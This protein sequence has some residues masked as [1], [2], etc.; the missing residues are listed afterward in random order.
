MTSL[1][2][3]T[4]N[5]TA[6]FIRSMSH[7]VLALGGNVGEVESTFRQALRALGDNGV[8]VLGAHLICI[9]HQWGTPCLKHSLDASIL[10]LSFALAKLRVRRC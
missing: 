7:A 10:S 6:N 8:K 1:A 2:L 3:R 5:V 9:T 4:R